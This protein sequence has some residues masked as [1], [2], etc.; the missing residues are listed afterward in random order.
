KKQRTGKKIHVCQYCEKQFDHFGHFK[1]HL[2]KHT[3]VDAKK[4]TV[5]RP[6][7]VRAL[8]VVTL[9]SPEA[10]QGITW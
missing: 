8:P 5:T 1:E 10:M 2:R 9:Q 3:V 7:L 4:F 6:H